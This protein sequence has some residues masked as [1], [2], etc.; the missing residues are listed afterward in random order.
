MSDRE[1]ANVSGEYRN[2][3]NCQSV[4]EML[5]AFNDGELGAAEQAQVENHLESCI[6]CREELA[7]LRQTSR[8]LSQLPEV[9]VPR[10]FTLPVAAPEPSKVFRWFGSLRLASGLAAA[11]LVFVLVFDFFGQAA[12]QTAVPVSTSA[13]APSTQSAPA[14]AG[15]LTATGN[16]ASRDAATPEAPATAPTENSGKSLAAA[17]A[18]E[19]TSAPAAGVPSGAPVAS[20]PDR[21]NATDS[22]SS[23]VTPAATPTGAAERPNTIAPTTDN[24][25]QFNAASPP[26]GQN[27]WLRL[28]EGVL[29]LIVIATSSTLLFIRRQRGIQKRR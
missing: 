23:A 24:G 3:Q 27:T 7:N 2:G 15:P 1:G 22:A 6:S 25:Q 16:A 4:I 12:I 5:S 20:E 18:R 21:T 19:G 26:A 29:V 9:S 28:V 14:D 11:L 8:L 10:S 13:S 17:P